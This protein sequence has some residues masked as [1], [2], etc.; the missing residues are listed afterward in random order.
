MRF[1]KI[2]LFCNER[3]RSR[4]SWALFFSVKKRKKNEKLLEKSSRSDFLNLKN[5]TNAAAMNEFCKKSRKFLI[6]RFQIQASSKQ[7]E[8]GTMHFLIGIT[9]FA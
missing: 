5:E 8:F 9:D 6:C 2:S 4:S 1:F 3:E 7:L